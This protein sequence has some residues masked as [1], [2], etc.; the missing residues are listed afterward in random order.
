V[1]HYHSWP[2]FRFVQWLLDWL[3]ALGEF[4][5]DWDAAN[6]S[7]S[8]QKHGVTCEEAEQVFTC[9]RFIPL[10]TQYQPPVPEARYAVLGE[11]GGGKLLFL[12]FALRGRSIRVISAR[13]MNRKEKAFYASLRE[14]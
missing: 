12:V 6:S 11:T 8:L 14:E 5:F 7:K 3:L 4:A 13:P 9:R 2:S 1:V 10:G